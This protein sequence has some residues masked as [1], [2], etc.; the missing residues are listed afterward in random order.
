MLD[1]ARR[2]AEEE[3]RK[4]AEWKRQ[5]WIR[6][7]E[8]AER[9]RQHEVEL[10]RQLKAAERRR[11]RLEK[12]AAKRA[13]QLQLK[14][15]R[16]RERWQKAVEQQEAAELERLQKAAEAA[17]ED[18][19]A[20]R[21]AAAGPYGSQGGQHGSIPLGHRFSPRPPQPSGVPTPVNSGKNRFSSPYTI[22]SHQS[23]TYDLPGG[24]QI[25]IG[26]GSNFSAAYPTPG[27]PPYMTPSHSG[28]YPQ[29]RPPSPAYPRYSARYDTLNKT[30]RP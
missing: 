9:A 10:D 13:Y 6:Q 26:V 18:E 8:A 27:Q 20:S 19:Q 17:W 5:Q 24:P 15:E 3:Q 21:A 22:N 29:Q 4:V 25:K 12:E 1:Q 7:Q 16:E 14:A 11:L 30:V 23:F 28:S 2:Q